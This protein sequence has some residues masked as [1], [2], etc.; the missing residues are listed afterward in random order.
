MASRSPPGGGGMKA[1]V[2]VDDTGEPVLGQ[3]Q[4]AREPDDDHA[5]HLFLYLP[6]LASTTG[7]SGHRVPELREPPRERRIGFRR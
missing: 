4:G 6:D 2:E 7:W 5:P 1:V 3:A